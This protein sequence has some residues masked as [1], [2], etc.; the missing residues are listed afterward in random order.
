MCVPHCIRCNGRDTR[1]GSTN[2]HTHL[3]SLESCKSFVC[4]FWMSFSKHS[5][6]W[7]KI[8][9]GVDEA[10]FHLSLLR[11]SAV[12]RL[13]FCRRLCRGSPHTHID[14]VLESALQ[15]PV[16]LLI[17]DDAVVLVLALHLRVTS[18]TV[19]HLGKIATHHR[20]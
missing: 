18:L 14:K 20:F 10:S 11:Q 13:R 8:K 1:S 12:L 16:F 9:G 6:S 7:R 4:A 3:L 2:V 17:G 19:R 5:C 15:L